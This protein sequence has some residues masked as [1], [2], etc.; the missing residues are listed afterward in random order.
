MSK[1]RFTVDDTMFRAQ[2]KRLVKKL[3][4][5]ES[6]FLREQG[7]LYARTMSKVTPP[8]AGGIFPKLKK[9]G[10][11]EGRVRDTVEAGKNAIIAD[12]KVM[13][14]VKSRGFLEFLHD[15]T[16]Q[17]S[18]IRRTLRTKKGDPYVIDVDEINYNSLPRALNWHQSHR[19][20][21]TVY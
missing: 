20:P 4:K 14:V 15:L 18:N 6:E 2:A 10:Y 12:M 16:G 17:L 1:V 21:S 7:A 13:F 8:H 19:Q 3:N 5:S 9:A 11:Q